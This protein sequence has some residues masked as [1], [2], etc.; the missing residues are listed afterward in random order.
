[1]FID[2]VKLSVKSGD[3]GAGC[4]SFRR[5]KFV[6]LGGPDGGDGGDG[7][8]VYFRVDKNSH[9]LSSYKG[10]REFKAQNGAPGEGRKKTGKS[11]EDLYLIVPPGTSVYD[12]DSGVLVLDMLNDGE[13]K[14]FLKGGKGGLGNV[15]FKSS[16]NQAPEYAQK[17]LPE[18]TRDVR[19]ELK[20]IADVGLVGFPNVGKSTLIST[21]SNA[22]PQIA[23][24]EFTTLT[25]KLGLVEV[26][27]YSG[28]VMADIPGI[29]EGASDGRGLGLKFLKHI[30]RTKI[31]L[32]MLDLA[33]YRSLKEQFVTLRG[34]VEKFSPELAKR[35]FAIALT[36]MDAAENLE[37]KV[38]EF[39]QILGLSGERSN[40][41]DEA[42][43]A[44]KN[45]IYKQDIYEFDDSKPYFVMPISSATNQNITELKFSLL[46]LLKKENFK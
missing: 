39:L 37:R 20:L 2:S 40:L 5:E 1:M 9:T 35:D 3:G 41:I 15:H 6:I 30:E 44:G 43:K 29:I 14:L 13:T 8:D 10:K 26:D 32:Y 34:E 19:L 21:V 18:E 25:P 12:E 22:K 33:N 45:L 16:I 36:R 23:N 17:G 24:Y 46:E 42:G 28:F 4:V 11:G 7:G 27:E 38:G 31:L